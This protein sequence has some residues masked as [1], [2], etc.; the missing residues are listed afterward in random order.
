[1]LKN[2]DIN[3]YRGIQNLQLDNLGKINIIA[4]ENNTGKTSILEVIE[5]LERPNSLRAWRTIGRR[6]GNVARVSTNLY[7]TMST[8]FPVNNYGNETHISYSGIADDKPF[9]VKISGKFSDV[10]L[11][12]RQMR[13]ISGYS[14]VA[15]SIDFEDASDSEEY[16]SSALDIEFFVNGEPY[17]EDRIYALGNGFQRDNNREVSIINNVLYISPTQHANNT[18]YLNSLMTNTQ[19]YEEFVEIMKQFDPDFYDIS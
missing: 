3:E 15:N 18:L 11:S 7:D 4:G 13:H 10:I 14:R 8:L 6:E 5:S 19:L 9:S 1:M 12:G 2:L 16:E 17:G